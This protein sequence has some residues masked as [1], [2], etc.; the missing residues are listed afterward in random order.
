MLVFLIILLC[1]SLYALPGLIATGRRHPGAWRI[2][3]VDILL[4][5]TVLGW[6]WS[7]REALRREATQYH[8]V[9][10]KY[11]YAYGYGEK[12][13]RKRFD[14]RQLPITGDLGLAIAG[15][16]VVAMFGTLGWQNMSPE[17]GTAMAAAAATTAPQGWTYSEDSDS[18]GSVRVS[19][20]MSDD[21][22]ATG[23]LIPGALIV[24]SGS[25]GPSAAL[26][27][28]GQFTCNAAAN[29]TIT[30]Q[31]D[32]ADAEALP[33][34]PR[35]TDDPLL[36]TDGQGMV[37][38]ANPETF[39]ARAN[40]SQKVTVSADV[41]GQGTRVLQFSPQGLNIAQAGL[42]EEAAVAVS[43]AKPAAVVAPAE[44][45]PA[46]TSRKTGRSTSAADTSPAPR[47][48]A[49]RDSP[50]VVHAVHPAPRYKSWHE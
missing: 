8:K 5:F 14:L 18:N 17:P 39:I 11:N 28:D 10:Y 32:A 40:R 13:S 29:G 44:D 36:A 23:N 46:V 47:H 43:M 9:Y 21:A 31:F 41:L 6:L 19:T 27:I 22:E 33:C 20:L 42:P 2:W 30:V 50:T 37:F 24:R 1:A 35:P 25:G 12:G 4:G 15:L 45:V 48:R 26:R 38:I 3:L 34:A 16:A 7:L 49:H